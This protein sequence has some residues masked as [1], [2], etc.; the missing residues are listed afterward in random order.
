MNHFFLTILL[1]KKLKKIF[2]SKYNFKNKNIIL[3]EVNKWPSVQ[4]SIAYLTFVLSGVLKTSNV[5]G[6]PENDFYKYLFGKNI[7]EKFYLIVNNFFKIKTY[8][9]YESFG[10]K[11][12]ISCFNKNSLNIKKSDNFVSDLY[13]KKVTPNTIQEIKIENI[14]IGDLIYD[15]YLKFYKKPTINPKDEDFI[16]FL[17]KSVEYFY[18]WFDF[19]RKNSVGGVVISQAV[20]NSSMPLRI[21]ANFGVK[22]FVSSPFHVYNITKKNTHYFNESLT[23]KKEFSKLSHSNKRAAIEITKKK[24]QKYFYSGAALPQKLTYMPSSAYSDVN[25]K[26]K[27]NRVL[28]KNKKIKVL[29]CPHALSD[30]P[31]SRGK[32]LYPDYYLWLLDI[33]KISKKTNYQWYLKLHPNYNQYWDNTYDIVKELLHTQ[34]KNVIFLD[35]QISHNQLISEGI[36]AVMTCTGSVSAEYAYFK[37]KSVNASLVNPHIK[38]SFSIHPKTKKELHKVILNI[39]KIKTKIDA[40]QVLIFYFM[41][42]IYYSNDWLLADL[43][44]TI[45]QCD[46]LSNIYKDIFY[47]HWLK[48]F[49]E[50]NHTRSIN[51]IKK[52]ISS[53]DYRINISH[54]DISL[55]KFLK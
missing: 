47:S 31:H 53:G 18:F 46:G 39:S 38:F 12:I 1:K 23:Y 54:Q 25:K 16:F 40:R 50:K 51:S 27:Y 2:R 41:Q 42:Q 35:N 48:N 19:Y 20:Y 33:L 17:R 24:L 34:Y 10:L 9:I 26:N 45:K 36:S 21:G 52:F 15:T 6:Y 49:N 14:L 32:H 11:K 4:I 44:K 5:Y 29:I 28:L 55:D 8:A 3:I 7:L 30:A 37:K 43:K 22:C 13:K